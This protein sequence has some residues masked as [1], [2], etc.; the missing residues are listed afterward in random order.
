MPYIAIKSYPKDEAVKKALVEKI[1]QDLLEIV[2]CHEHAVTISYE[3]IEPEK[4]KETVVKTE[5]EP[6]ADKM[7][8]VSGEKKY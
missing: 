5:I 1:N 2:G 6:K 4:W 7:Y 3:E 8:I